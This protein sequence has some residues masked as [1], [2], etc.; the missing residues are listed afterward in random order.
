LGVLP[1]GLPPSSGAR[2]TLVCPLL[3]SHNYAHSRILRCLLL[4]SRDH[5][6]ACNVPFDKLCW[7]VLVLWLDG[8]VRRRGYIGVGDRF[9]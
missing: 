7:E 5:I 6:R 1:S 8:M 4:C 2:V 3:S 9:S